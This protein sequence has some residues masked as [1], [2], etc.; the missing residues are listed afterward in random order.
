M[1]TRSTVR[2]S[3]RSCA[4]TCA[5]SASTTRAAPRHQAGAGDRVD[6][7]QPRVRLPRQTARRPTL[8]RID[9][10]PE[11]DAGGESALDN[12]MA[13]ERR[14]EL[15]HLLAGYSDKD[16]TFV[17]LYYAH[18][19]EAEEVAGEMGISVKTVYSKNHKLLARLQRTLQPMMAA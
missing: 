14:A 16:R 11:V 9:G 8:D 6:L 10:L 15:N 19:L 2:S 7:D 5:S 13:G 17:A 12:I 4:T 3:W 18:G 1:P